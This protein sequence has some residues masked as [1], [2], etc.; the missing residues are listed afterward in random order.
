MPPIWKI[1]PMDGDLETNNINIQMS[2]GAVLHGVTQGSSNKSSKVLG[3]RNLGRQD[4][5][6][7]M[8]SQKSGDDN[9]VV[10]EEH[11]E[12]P[13]GHATNSPF[14]K[15]ACE[16]SDR[17]KKIEERKKRKGKTIC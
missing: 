5:N 4:E 3:N 9:S 17:S 10:D 6:P 15:Q 12:T 11:V 7:E 1:F 16:L 14:N 8:K 2:N 13:G